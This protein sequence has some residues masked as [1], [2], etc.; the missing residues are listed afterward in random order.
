M[1][2]TKPSVPIIDRHMCVLRFYRA[3]IAAHIAVKKWIDAVKSEQD[4]KRAK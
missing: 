2:M 3:L 4:K 1:T